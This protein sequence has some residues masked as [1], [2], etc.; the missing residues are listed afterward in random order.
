MIELQY[1][2]LIETADEPDYFGFC[3]PE[4]E[5][6]TGIG[7]SVKDCFYKAKWGMEEHV[8]LLKDQGLPVPP[9]NPDPKIIIQNEK[10]A[11]VA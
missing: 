5:G 8:D 10:K 9:R 11:A 6:F 2:L 7:H 3:Y 4:L 1:S